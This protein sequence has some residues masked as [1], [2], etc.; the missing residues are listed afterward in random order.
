MQAHVRIRPHLLHCGSMPSKLRIVHVITRFVNGG[1][2]ENTLLTCNH[3]AEAGHE[4]WLV[5]GREWTER[6]KG[7]LDPRVKPVELKTLVRDISPLDD[8]R[9]LFSLAALYRRIRP[10]VIHTH[11]S[12]GG[13]LGRL[14]APVW[15][16][17]RVIHGVHILPFTNEPFLK[18]S[19][20]LLLEK[21]T[22]LR[23]HAFIDVSEGMRDLCLQ[24][25]LG[26]ESNHFVI[27]SGMDVSRFRQAAPAD[28]LA[29][30]RSGKEGIVI[31]GYVAVLERRKRHRELVS[32]IAPLLKA[33]PQLVLVFAG[34]GPERCVLEKLVQ[35][36]GIEEQVRLLG[37]REDVDRVVAACDICVFASQREGLPR[38]VVQYVIGGKPV[39][40]AALPGIERVVAHDRNGFVSPGD[41]LDGVAD[42]VKRLL[43]DPA[44]RQRFAEASAAMDLSEWDARSMTDRIAE[45]Y[46]RY[47]G[48]HVSSTPAVESQAR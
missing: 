7:K 43:L 18:R 36:E 6:M 25:S 33:H 29:G 45:V 22:A 47:I 37:F 35:D 23:T 26:N 20:Y 21:L 17:A 12:K 1:A 4:V 5:Y 2:D 28:D 31:A 40:A 3:Q 30:L 44:L 10:D 8:L 9:A 13:I 15:P 27:R 38:S 42:G 46:S 48:G 16:S 34:D 32:A 14:A 24:H 19:I 41:S 39:V 11:T